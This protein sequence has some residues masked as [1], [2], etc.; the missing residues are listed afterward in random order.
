MKSKAV[1]AALMAASL[2]PAAALAHGVSTIYSPYVHEGEAAVEVKG[3]YKI[4]EDDSDEDSFAGEM[5]VGYGLTHFWQMEAGA[6]LEH[7]DEDDTRVTALVWEN[8]FQLAPEGALF[9]DPGLKIEYEKSLTGEA[10]EVLARLLLAKRIGKFTNLSN[11]NF[12][13]E[14]GEDSS[15]DWEY[16]FSYGLSYNHSETFSYGLEWHSDFGDFEGDYSEQEHRVGP[17][18]YGQLAEGIPFEAGV[19]FGV[20]EHAPDAELKAVI[21]YEF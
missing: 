6:E 14:V 12:G 9:V 8:K 18:V 2:Y 10:D 20:S 16:G 17:A 7:N 5:T 13:R 4:N 11:I 15:G 21:E 19:L 1:F 3:S